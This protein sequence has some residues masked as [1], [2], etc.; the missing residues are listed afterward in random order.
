MSKDENAPKN[1][2]SI[3]IPA[4]MRSI[5][6]AYASAETRIASASR[7]EQTAE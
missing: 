4:L 3:G 7:L 6:N 2:L 5:I 1:P